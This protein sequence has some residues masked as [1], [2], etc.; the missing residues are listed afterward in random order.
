[1]GARAAR[2]TSLVALV[3]VGVLLATGVVWRVVVGA[4][5][6]SFAAHDALTPDDVARPVS[7]LRSGG[8]GSLVPWDSLGREG[9]VFTAGGPDADQIA[10]VTGAE[11]QQPIRVYAGVASADTAQQQA[12]LAVRTSTGPAASTAQTCWWSPPPGPGGSSRAR[13]AASSTS[14]VG[15]PRSSAMQYSHLPSWLSFLVDRPAPGSREGPVRRGL[16]ALVQPP[17]RRPAASCTSS[18]RASARSARRTPSAASSTSPTAPAAGSRGSA[19]L[20][21]ALPQFIDERD[22]GSRGGRAGLPGRRIIRFTTNRPSAPAGGR[23]VA[24]SR[25][26]YL[27]HASDPI[28]WWSPD[29]LLTR[30]DW[31]EEPRGRDVLGA[32]RWIPFDDL[33]A[34]VGRPRPRVLHHRPATAT[35]TPAS[36][37]TGGPPSCSPTAGRRPGPTSCGGPSGRRGAERLPAVAPG[38]GRVTRS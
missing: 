8:P 30:P 14:P 35:T 38:T 27:Q 24:G 25:V 20:R 37:S 6:A 2:A 11:A 28:T 19:E 10:A 16:R 32:M 9:R 23:A 13:R 17:V 33:L 22:A 7:E 5:D 3:A 31:L 26:L 4:A 12:E 21:P 29:L 18:A 15:T 36:T 1:M 34:A